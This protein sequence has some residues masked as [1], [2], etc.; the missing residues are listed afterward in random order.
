M[1]VALIVEWLEPWRGGAETSARQ[2]ID[3]LSDSGVQLDIIT[4]SHI[5]PRP[6]MNVHTVRVSGPSRAIKT[7]NFVRKADRCAR[8]L[9]VDA[10][11]AITAIPSCDIY[12]PRGGTIAETLVRDLVA[13]S[14]PV[15]R[16]LKR[17]SA[18]LNVKQRWLLNLERRLLATPGGPTVIAISDYVARQ[19]AS[20]YHVAPD[21]IARI[22]N[23][24]DPDTADAESRAR[25]RRRIR[26]MYAVADDEPLAIMVAHNFRLKGLQSWI[27]ALAKLRQAGSRVRSLVIGAGSIAP[28]QRLVLRRGLG[29]ALRFTGPTERVR[30]F[31][32]SADMLV[33][34]TF[35][36]PCSRV[37]LEAMVSGLA[38][39]T[40]RFDGA[41]EV[42][43][44][45]EN[46][47]V[48]DGPDD[49]EALVA[50]VRRLE[51]DAAL[52][53]AMG[54]RATQVASRVS[55]EAHAL[56]VMSLY[57]S[58]RAGSKRRDS[59]PVMA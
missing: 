18:T 16:A 22:Y 5:S 28:W 49:V 15:S 41:S 47:W 59:A 43:E 55:M 33:H 37:V 10:V 20:H 2:F 38:V 7:I 17:A 8:G 13:R 45:G 19:L 39:I 46:G 27:E 58:L 57:E 36:D 4:R 23:G 26:A 42:I 30:A 11:H 3:H 12:Q 1:R 6:G 48:I 54:R 44:P 14:S 40:T 35:Y 53:R 56:K 50:G 31:Y 21:R 32:H 34:P 25:D 29:T 24:V 52:R 9:G 51:T